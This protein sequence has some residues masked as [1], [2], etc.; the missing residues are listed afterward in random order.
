MGSWAFFCILGAERQRRAGEIDAKIARQK[1]EAEAEA[2][3]FGGKVQ[4]PIQ[5]TPAAPPPRAPAPTPSPAKAA[6]AKAKG[7]R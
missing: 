2:A 4:A 7:A 1:A 5:K 3:R 6:P